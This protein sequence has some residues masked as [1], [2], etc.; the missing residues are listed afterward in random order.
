MNRILRTLFL[1]Q[2]LFLGIG[3]VVGSPGK[4]DL[5]V[6]EVYG[7]DELADKNATKLS[8]AENSN[9]NTARVNLTSSNESKVKPVML[10]AV[11]VT[12]PVS[13]QITSTPED[14]VAY[15]KA[16]GYSIVATMEDNLETTLTA[17]TL[18]AWMSFRSGGV[19]SE[20][21]LI[22]TL[23]GDNVYNTTGTAG[24]SE[25]NIYTSSYNS[26]KGIYKI[27]PDGTYSS[28]RSDLLGTNAW[29]L[30][31]YDGYLYI[32]YYAN[33][34][35]SVTRIPLND[36]AA[37]EETM[38]AVTQ[39]VID[40]EFIDGAFYALS[41]GD[42]KIYKVNI[43]TKA[44]ETII[45]SGLSLAY[46]FDI[47]SEGNLIIA[48]SGSYKILKYSSDGTLL[49]TSV[50]SVLATDIVAVAPGQY[51]TIFYGEEG[52]RLYN[53]DFTSY[54][55]IYE[56]DNEGSSAYQFGEGAGGSILWARFG[57]GEVYAL[58]SGAMLSGTPGKANVGTHNVVIRAT[59]DA[60]YTEQS[61][62][63]TVIDT[64]APEIT[65]V[66][67]AD[68]S[69]GVGLKPTLQMTFD[70][71][72]SLASEGTV[73]IYEGEMLFKT[74]DLTVT[75]DRAAF[76]I[77][78]DQKTL[79]LAI[80]DALPSNSYIV[81]DLS[82]GFVKDSSDNV[83]A[84]TMATTGSWN[85]TTMDIT[86]PIVSTDPVSNLTMTSA[87]L[88]GE[89]SS[90][91]GAT[92]TER[93]ILYSTKTTPVIAADSVTNLVLGDGTGT[94]SQSVT[95]LTEGTVYY[96]RAYAINDIDTS[97]ADEVVFRTLARP[98]ITS[99]PEDTV[100]YDKAY[101]YSIVATME[102]TLETTLT[103]PTLP[104]W[105]SFSSGGL[106]F[107]PDLI[108]TLTG[109]YANQTMGTA[110]DSEGNIYT[111][112]WNYPGIYKIT[113]DGT[114]SMWRSELLGGYV[115]GLDVYDGY[116]YLCDHDNSTNSVTRIPLND[117]TAEEETMLSVSTGVIDIEFIDGAFYALSMGTN[118]L[119]KVD[120][121]TK[122]AETV[123]SSGLSS[124]YG[125]DIDSEGNLIIASTNSNTILKYS[126][127]GTFLETLGNVQAADIVAVAP[128]QYLTVFYNEA[129]VRLYNSDFTSYEQ[130]H[131][132]NQ[133]YQFGE[134]AGGSILWARYMAGE[135]YALQSGA[136]LS[137]TPGKANLGT[138]NV[139]IRATNDAGYTEQS[140]TVTVIDT[141]APDV[142]AVDTT[143]YLDANGQASIT[144]AEVSASTDDGSGIETLTLSQT[145]FACADV[146][147]PYPDISALGAWEDYDLV[148]LAFDYS[149]GEYDFAAEHDFTG[150]AGG[151]YGIDINPADNKLYVV[152][153]QGS[154][155]Q[156][157]LY[158]L[159]PES[160]ELTLLG[161]LISSDENVYPQ[162]LSF[163]KNGNAF[164]AYKN[165]TIDKLN[166][167]TMLASK[168]ADV[169]IHGAVGMTYDFDK[170]RLIYAYNESPYA[171]LEI[172]NSGTVN[173][174]FLI[175]GD[176]FNGSPESVV[177]QAI[178]Y[179]GNGRCIVSGTFG[180]NFIYEIDL[181]TG[182]V[183]L[184]EQYGV[185]VPDGNIKD[186]VYDWVGNLKKLT[187][188]DFSGNTDSV[189]VIITVLD[190]LAPELGVQD[191]TVYL[192]SIGKGWINGA[193]V[194]ASATDNCSV[195]DTLL[196]VDTF[197][198][199]AVEIP[200]DVLVT[201][202]DLS[203]NTDTATVVVTV[204]DTIKPEA[205]GKDLT[206]YLDENGQASIDIDSMLLDGSLSCGS[207]GGTE[208][209]IDCCPDCSGFIISTEDWPEGYD[210]DYLD[211]KVIDI[212][213]E[214]H[215]L[216]F[217]F[218]DEGSL[219]Y[220]LDYDYDGNDWSTAVSAYDVFQGANSFA[221]P[222]ES[223][224]ASYEGCPDNCGEITVSLSDTT[225]TGENVGENTITVYTTDLHD[226]VSEK[227]V[228]ITVVD[229]VA[230]DV[231]A[232]D[233]TLY[234][235]ANGQASITAAEVSASTDN[236]SGI[237][238]LTLSQTSF[239]CDDVGGYLYA[240]IPD[241]DADV[242]GLSF[243]SSANKYEYV[244]SV[245][246]ATEGDSYG[247][248]KN[249]VNKKIYMIRRAE[250]EGDR[251]LY[252]YNITNGQT[253]Y[254]GE[255]ESVVE[256]NPQDLT[257]DKDGNAYVVYDDGTI[258]KM[259]VE[260]MESALFTDEIGNDRDEKAGLTY[261]F[262]NDRL[263]YAFRNEYDWS[264]YIVLEILMDGT[265]NELFVVEEPSDFDGEF[266]G[267]QAIEYI[268][269]NECLVSTA[270][271]SDYI[272]KI[273]LETEAITFTQTPNGISEIDE[274][275]D[276]IKDFFFDW[277]KEPIVL[278]A[279]DFSG[280]TDSVNVTITVLDT[281]APVASC[282]D[283]WL[284]PNGAGELILDVDMIDNGST[285]N[286]AIDTMY[287]SQSVFSNDMAGE[288]VEVDLIVKDVHGN[289]SF[290]TSLVNLGDT[291][292]PEVWCKDIGINLN[293]DGT[294]HLYPVF[295]IDSVFDNAG[296][297]SY[298]LDIRDFDCGDI[299][300]HSVELSVKDFGG[301]TTTCTS[302]V[303]VVDNNRPIVVCSN[304]EVALGVDGTATITVDDVDGG[305]TDACG[306]A[307]REL[308]Q[309]EFTADNIG[310]NNVTLYVSDVNGN[311]DS[312]TAV[313]TVVK[314]PMPVVNC[315]AIDVVIAE[316]DGYELSDEDLAALAAGTSDDATPFDSLIIVATP[317]VFTCDMIGD[318][319]SVV[320]SVSDLDGN[321]STCE[322]TVFV[323]YVFDTNIADVEVRLEAGVCETTIDYPEL[324]TTDI[325]GSMTLIDGL[326]VDGM[327]PAGTTIETWEV[328]LG[329]VTDTVSFAV[330]VSEAGQSGPSFDAISD[331]SADENELVEVAVSGINDGSSCLDKELVLTATS[332][333][334]GLIESI[335]TDYEAGSTSG[336]LTINLVANQSGSAEVVVQIA[337]EFG[338]TASDTF[339]VSVASGNSTPVLVNAIADIT[340]QAEDILEV[341]L[342]T[343]L[344]DVFNDA[345][346]DVLTWSFMLDGDTILNW[347][348][349][350]ELANEYILNFQPARADTGCFNVIVVVSDPSG[351]SAT[352]TF[353]VCVT[354]IPVA[355]NDLGAETVVINM[356][357]NPT[358]GNVTLDFGSMNNDAEVWITDI[359][360]RL[361]FNKQYQFT[362][363]VAIDLS[364][365]V[366]GNYLVRMN[367][368]GRIE[369]KKLILKK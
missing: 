83:Y 232:V 262:D 55:Q 290:C 140:F 133:A 17:P 123:I 145:S 333:N 10:G 218:F 33:V 235:D 199:D 307:S 113:P 82:T 116:L 137:G 144:A 62:T 327:F 269:N 317:S 97:Y 254:V 115:W 202:T 70:E 274:M 37:E 268:G 212:F 363:R 252:E 77:S 320:V 285:D 141:L 114:Y 173:E 32:C 78:E 312:C 233:T 353:E 318:S 187:A 329:G 338:A 101:S 330:T 277:S 127:E 343:V 29:G 31:V 291:I 259:N 275:Y 15:D 223:G 249:P 92:V 7:N 80:S 366:S 265:V 155:S 119:Y 47:D 131:V 229:T 358:K 18:P 108:A 159:E 256:D 286:C 190:T 93:G 121:E 217:S 281:L 305:S 120:I 183:G 179:I 60:G 288:Q 243:N 197:G 102:D 260:T 3:T 261:D 215:T 341:S 362:D 304:Y 204:L 346:G 26:E 110:G 267:G 25:G 324:F 20:A 283:Y 354:Q 176:D 50:E 216:Y 238:T 331:I 49:E 79:S 309:S 36:P 242:M 104:A 161:Q 339:V 68:D 129:G 319:V 164:V 272:H 193:D 118:K 180:S 336:M 321:E 6:S 284:L 160:F 12:E 175:S 143:L 181:S 170:D 34:T 208:L 349:V 42:N 357:P 182:N 270:G 296:I 220:S 196:S 348:S 166:V 106:S 209:G 306:I 89:V 72:I 264:E 157:Y 4:L 38:L 194:V 86:A 85:F 71:G 177:A 356:Y 345:D 221:F 219:L 266:F 172:T 214:T 280:N 21:D 326:G 88:G 342:S 98:V 149:A 53:S 360:G 245:E 328:I 289:S 337:D 73:K 150:D 248:D 282:K 122:E 105:M 302:E 1:L 11:T 203:G 352:D 95:D 128:G 367:L 51:L 222:F 76:S 364:N 162:D 206:L 368:D 8:E 67:P 303:T 90:D 138:H 23:T 48:N 323:D 117:P 46:G 142:V 139:V 188:T 136:K 54:E 258:Y 39:G 227:Q 241:D 332:L 63:V 230:P 19:A 44:V 295:V 14:T 148:K 75:D 255:L 334:I 201:I 134:G 300:T 293:V 237:E 130:I 111:C 244:N 74:F 226:N 125:F 316:P 16:Y 253:D 351:A 153:D 24:D 257:F 65:A 344:G 64:I 163:D 158:R 96:V 213:G 350:S 192:D 369:M 151:N 287:L 301:N 81:V 276:V 9:F 174:L 168:H 195:V 169:G 271:Y 22:A 132:G 59:N 5:K 191:I 335:T 27:T 43:E 292:P 126:S 58:Q 273:N 135:V 325:C 109:D 228:T 61:F 156:R 91:G 298:N 279:T 66:I 124:P 154:D 30:D 2:F 184:L 100:A 231:V 147:L 84:G 210:Y 224:G 87:T 314:Q 340:V 35:N 294:T 165:G 310:A 359:S 311:T 186:L 112:L 185:A 107:E 234:L 189:G 69:T 52:V 365:H 207:S 40:M 263:I 171:L 205:Q 211:G 308:S 57:V 103:A 297:A 247:F 45:S 225:F 146:T 167:S 99:T 152:R 239:A 198:C 41:K 347:M 315:N 240:L 178:E 94:F 299:G 251:S 361:I 278:T 322:T 246:Y 13:P 250:G 313:V 56:A 200:V 236:G 355:V 28:W